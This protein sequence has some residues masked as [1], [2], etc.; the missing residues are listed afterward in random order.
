M[1]SNRAPAHRLSA[2]LVCAGLSLLGVVGCA[3]DPAGVTRSQTTSTPTS[4]TVAKVVTAGPA[5][6]IGPVARRFPMLADGSVDGWAAGT[7][8]G[9]PGAPDRVPGPTT[10]WFDAIV[11]VG[12]AQVA[13]WAEAYGA[14]AVPDP[15]TVA[16]ELAPFVPAGGLL[17]SANLDAAFSSAQ[18]TATVFLSPTT[19]RVVVLGIHD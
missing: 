5:R 2:A 10:H 6:D 13:A 14:G 18:W 4:P 1:F 15:G 19:G 9:A 7:V 12:T 11:D 16:T 3:T 17:G 8:G